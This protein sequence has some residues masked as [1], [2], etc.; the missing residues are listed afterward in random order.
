MKERFADLAKSRLHEMS[1]R[2][3]LAASHTGAPY[4]VLLEY[5]WGRAGGRKLVRR[6]ARRPGQAATWRPA[7]REW[8]HRRIRM[9]R[10]ASTVPAPGRSTCVLYAFSP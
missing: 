7:A 1:T 3:S 2:Q 5:V 10:L 4:S 6:A 8:R 9:R